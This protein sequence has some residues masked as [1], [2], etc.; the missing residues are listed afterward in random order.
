[1]RMQP[2]QFRKTAGESA[3]EKSPVNFLKHSLGGQRFTL[4]GKFDRDGRSARW[5]S[6]QR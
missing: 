3:P 5:S 4:F 6:I 2:A 1:M